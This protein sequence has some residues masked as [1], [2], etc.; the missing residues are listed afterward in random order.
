MKKDFKISILVKIAGLSS[1]FLFIAILVLAMYSINQ[2]KNVSLAA[3]TAIVQDKL[4]GDLNSAR[5]IITDVY[6]ELQIGK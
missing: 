5:Y 3:S 6:G 4:Q 2:M 1:G